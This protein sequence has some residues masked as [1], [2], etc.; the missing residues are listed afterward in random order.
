MALGNLAP[1]APAVVVVKE[2]LFAPRTVYFNTAKNT[3]PVDAAF[4]T[5]IEQAKIYLQNH[6]DKKLL[7]TGYTDNAGQ[8]EK[9]QQLSV[10]RAAFVKSELM[11]TGIAD[12]RMQTAGKGQDDPVAENNTAEGKAKNRRVTIQLQ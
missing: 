8:A 9:N 6:A 2:D 12:D 1:A 11:K 4:T 7:I 3:M 10:S 5:Y